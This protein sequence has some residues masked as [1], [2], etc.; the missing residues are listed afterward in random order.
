MIEYFLEKLGTRY[1]D[2]PYD[3]LSDSYCLLKRK[4]GVFDFWLEK[5]P[6]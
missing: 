3:D 1:I 2:Q 4:F 6:N 5:E